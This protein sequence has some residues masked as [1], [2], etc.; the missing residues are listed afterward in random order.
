MRNNR[1]RQQGSPHASRVFDSIYSGGFSV[2]SGIRSTQDR[3]RGI[4]TAHNKTEHPI[5][6][7]LCLRLHQSSAP[8]SCG[9]NTHKGR[10][11]ARKS[12]TPRQSTM[13]NR[14]VH[15][16]SWT[17]RKQRCISGN[18]W[19]RAPRPGRRRGNHAAPWHRK[20]PPKNWSNTASSCFV[21]D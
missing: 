9:Y 3:L 21:L 17:S 12:F 20:H 6:L 18:A 14:S 2:A 1:S 11:S 15:S 7:S 19:H 8:L 4:Q 10:Y 5:R 16:V 13:D